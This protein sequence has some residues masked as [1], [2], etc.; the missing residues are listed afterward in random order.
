MRSLMSLSA[1]ALLT[2]GVVGIPHK[3]RAAG[4]HAWNLKKFTSLV[5]F[6]DSYTDESRL[7]YF[8]SHNG[9]APPV[10]WVEPEASFLPLA[11]Y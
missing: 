6:G 5:A 1:L 2:S 7:G 8:G 11:Y 3:R 4:N 9:M 10:G